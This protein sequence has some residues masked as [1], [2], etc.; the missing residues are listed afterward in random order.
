MARTSG[1]S[2]RLVEEIVG[3][4]DV[5]ERPLCQVYQNAGPFGK[6]IVTLPDDKLVI[7]GQSC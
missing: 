2:S 7:F 4:G 1:I 6:G 3:E 5:F